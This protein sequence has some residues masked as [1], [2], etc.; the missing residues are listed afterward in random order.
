ML[1]D[2]GDPQPVRCVSGEHPFDVIIEYCR[3]PAATASAPLAVVNTLQ[4]GDG[5]LAE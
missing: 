4:P 3:E 2:V 1:R 5:Q